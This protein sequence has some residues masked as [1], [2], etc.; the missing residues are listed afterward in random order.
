MTA[1]EAQRNISFMSLDGIFMQM[2]LDMQFTVRVSP[3]PS[4]Y[5]AILVIFNFFTLPFLKTCHIHCVSSMK[6]NLCAVLKQA[7][8]LLVISLA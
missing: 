5:V 6:T 7:A 8:E 1:E 4:N 3:G 2:L